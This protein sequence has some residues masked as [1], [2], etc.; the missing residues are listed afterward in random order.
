MASTIQRGDTI[1]A[2]P[3]GYRLVYRGGHHNVYCDGT[4][5]IWTGGG[6]VWPDEWPK[7]VKSEAGCDCA[8]WRG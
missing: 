1:A 4:R 6:F 8:R 7:R 3:D 2:I 5:H